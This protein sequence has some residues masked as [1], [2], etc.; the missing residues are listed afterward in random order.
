L[1]ELAKLKGCRDN[2][3]EEDLMVEVICHQQGIIF[4][5][6]QEDGFCPA[7]NHNGQGQRAEKDYNKAGKSKILNELKRFYPC[8]IFWVHA[9]FFG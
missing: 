8:Y 5:L 1:N 9:V 7:G 6:F 4:T 3:L 2:E